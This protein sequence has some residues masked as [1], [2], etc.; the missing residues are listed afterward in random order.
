M[1]KN[2]LG[3]VALFAVAVGTT[4][5][6]KEQQSQVGQ[7]I[8]DAF[9]GGCS[10]YGPWTES[11]LGH[12]SS[13]ISVVQSL[14]AKDPCKPLAATLGSIQA[15]NS[16][17]A[18]L[19]QNEAYR[20]YKS[21]EESIQELSL[22]LN[23]AE[24]ANNA[25]LRYALSNALIT[26][27]A[28]RA[29]SKALARNDQFATAGLQMASTLQSLL[30]Q[31]QDLRACLSSSPGAAVQL[32]TNVLALGGS[33]VSPVVG[34][35]VGMI[36][37]MI[38]TGVEYARTHASNEAL[39]K[40]YE[41]K[42]PMA[43]T[44]GLEAMTDLY[45]RA[46]DAYSLIELQAKSYSAPDA[47]PGPLWEG[48]DL[49]GRRMPV[50][51]SWLRRLKAGVAPTDSNEA[52]R[53][54]GIWRRQSSVQNTH[55]AVQGLLGGM[56]NQYFAPGASPESQRTYLLGFLI[57]FAYSMTSDGCQGMNCPPAG[58][59]FAELTSNPGT[60]ACYIVLGIDQT[61]ATTC[62][63]YN[64]SADGSLE[65][66]IRNHLLDKADVLTLEEHWNHIRDRVQATVDTEFYQTITV[67]PELLLDTAFNASSDNVS[68]RKVLTLLDRYLVRLLE[69]EDPS[70]HYRSVR[71]GALK[72]VRDAEQALDNTDGGL[73]DK[74]RVKLLFEIFH[75]KDAGG[76][77]LPD[78]ISQIVLMDVQ[79]QL[80]AGQL[81]QEVS[82]LLRAAGGDVRDRL[83]SAGIRD[84]SRIVRDLNHAR[85]AEEANIQNFTHF[86]SPSFARAV[87]SLAKRAR[88]DGE[89]KRGANR[90]NSQTLAE[91]C[92]LMVSTGA[93]WPDAETHRICADSTLSSLYSRPQSRVD[94][95]LTVNIGRLER[96]L[97]AVPMRQ[98]L[99]AYSRYKR[100]E[101]IAEVVNGPRKR[102][103]L[104]NRFS[105]LWTDRSSVLDPIPSKSRFNPDWIWSLFGP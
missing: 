32:A 6:P 15:L 53:Q 57:E 43:L 103:K 97:S 51:L 99:C 84:L 44:C 11:A 36:G 62:P 95:P 21:S 8:L 64:P 45:C 54:I 104:D 94:D 17:L 89:P 29:S 40:A 35:S 5:C 93:A 14:Q 2:L 105:A 67:N 31:A 46:G 58:G 92:A 25:D 41:T 72:I 96:E 20:D 87:K 86:F 19:S 78:R 26:A 85:Q 74:A 38:N 69:Q 56:K 49:L 81:P 68:P 83:T 10:S 7:E 39:W 80:D 66:Y 48:I 23:S 98:R 55:I 52:R 91:L 61:N 30:G 3:V 18:F 88:L 33:F 70:P 77:I 24:A 47:E 28:T 75:L 73:D 9:A 37:Q 59:P 71:E 101:R 50:L 100:A 102:P 63:L 12:T 60:Y 65:S 42:M 16:Q 1:F 76:K 27:Q 34:A 79:K 90:P 22:A 4:G 82:E 13:L